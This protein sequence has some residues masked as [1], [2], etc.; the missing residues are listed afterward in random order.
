[1]VSTLSLHDA[2]PI[3]TLSVATTDYRTSPDGQ[4]QEFT[5]WHRIVVWGRQAENCSKY[6][7]K[8]RS[9]LVEGRLQT[10]SWEDKQ[11]QKRYTTEIIAQNVQCVGGGGATRERGDSMGGQSYGGGN[12]NYGGGNNYGGQDDYAQAPMGEPQTPGLDVIPF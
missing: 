1:H 6:L 8:G 2:L 5:E 7:A 10:R 4:R 12:Q 9:V 11:G 3:C